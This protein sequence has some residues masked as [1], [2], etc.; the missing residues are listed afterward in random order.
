MKLIYGNMELTFVP[1]IVQEALPFRELNTALSSI[2]NIIS[3]TIQYSLL[4]GIPPGYTRITIN[5]VTL[6]ICNFNTVLV[7]RS[8]VLHVYNLYIKAQYVQDK[9]YHSVTMATR[10]V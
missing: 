5:I 3:L 10:N 9:E 8:N 2:W 7:I 4:Y 6:V 1:N